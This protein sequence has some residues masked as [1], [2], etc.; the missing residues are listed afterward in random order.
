MACLAL[1]NYSKSDDNV[2]YCPVGFT[3]RDNANG[4]VTAGQWWREILSACGASKDF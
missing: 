3:D 4:E 1:R 2:T